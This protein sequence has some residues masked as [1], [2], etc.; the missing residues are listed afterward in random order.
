[1]TYLR[2]FFLMMF[3]LEH[4]PAVYDGPYLQTL[5]PTMI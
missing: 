5:S 3:L 4:D 2:L 1:M